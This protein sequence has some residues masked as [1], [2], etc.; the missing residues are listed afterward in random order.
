MMK[1]IKNFFELYHLMYILR[2]KNSKIVLKVLHLMKKNIIAVIGPTGVGKSNLAIQLATAFD[3][4]IINAD[5]MQVYKGL[6]IITNK[7]SIK[8][9]MGIPHHLMDEIDPIMEYTV[10]DWTSQASNIITEIHSRNKIPI[11]VGGT[12]Y[13]LQSILTSQLISSTLNKTNNMDDELNIKLENLLEKSKLDPNLYAEE[14]SHMLKIID[15]VMGNRWHP[16]D[17]RK[18]RR[19]L[20]VFYT[21]GQKQSDIIKNQELDLKYRTCIVWPFVDSKILDPRLDARIN[22]MIKMGLVEEI[23][24]FYKN[25]PQDL[26]Y[27]RGIFQAIGFKEFN[28]YLSNRNE[29]SFQEGIEL[30]KLHTRQY[31]KRQVTWIKNRLLGRL[32]GPLMSFICMDV[33]DL[34]QWGNNSK[35]IMTKVNEFLDGKQVKEL[36]KSLGLR[37]TRVDTNIMEWKQFECEICI[38][39]ITKLPRIFNGTHEWQSHLE[40]RI[41]KRNQRFLAKK[42]QI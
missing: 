6:D 33:S 5:S 3:G 10:Q 26:D 18:L 16:R 2:Y 1:I 37:F 31:A 7:I 14:M 41:H 9:R 22:E 36:P 15:P 30:M 19:S 34:S 29:K 42:R 39:R 35:C 11:L 21:M 23:E 17:G 28:D 32:D 8:E 40:S 13:Y 12:H 24:G 4:E 20:E 25:F 38:D 27:T